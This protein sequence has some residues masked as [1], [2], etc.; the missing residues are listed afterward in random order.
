[1]IQKHSDPTGVLISFYAVNLSLSD[2][3]HPHDIVLIKQ[4]GVNPV[5]VHGG[6]PMIDKILS[7]LKVESQF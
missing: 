5:I 1:M 6:G 3:R 2:G 7:D 4:C